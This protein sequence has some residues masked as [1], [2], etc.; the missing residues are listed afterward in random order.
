MHFG[1]LDARHVLCTKPVRCIG[2]K[3]PVWSRGPAEDKIALESLYRDE[4]L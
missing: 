3:D 1:T 2:S 4:D